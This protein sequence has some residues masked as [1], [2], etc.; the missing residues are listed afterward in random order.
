M[1]EVVITKDQLEA[2]GPCQPFHLKSPEWDEEREALVYEDWEATVKRL[3]STKDGLTQLGW[4][5]AHNLVPMTRL[6]FRAVRKAK[7]KMRAKAAKAEVKA[8]K[9]E[10]ASA[11]VG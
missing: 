11:E 8:R 4:L 9:A 2:G 6:E 10:A 3:S 5:V 1:S 7:Q